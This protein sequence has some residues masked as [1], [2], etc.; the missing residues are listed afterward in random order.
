MISVTIYHDQFWISPA[1]IISLLSLQQQQ[2]QQQQQQPLLK[3]TDNGSLCQ[4]WIILSVVLLL[5][6]VYC[7]RDDDLEWSQ[8]YRRNIKR[9]TTLWKLQIPSEIQTDN[10]SK[11]T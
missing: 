5:S 6:W 2:Q 8:S 3:Y 9:L 1:E 11:Q 10:K 4:L 7:L